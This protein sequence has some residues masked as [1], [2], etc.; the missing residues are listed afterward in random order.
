MF[1]RPV[2]SSFM[3]VVLVLLIVSGLVGF[4]QGKPAMPPSLSFTPSTATASRNEVVTFTYEFTNDS[5]VQLTNI[6]AVVPFGFQWKNISYTVTN[7]TATRIPSPNQYIYSFT[8][9]N[10]APTEKVTIVFQATTPKLLV[11]PIVNLPITAGV[12]WQSTE[13][14]NGSLNA[15]ANVQVN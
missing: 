4:T 3:L 13:T 10:L 15:T 7:G 6:K 11:A 14:P 2:Y 12:T 1:H 5:P 9:G 8:V